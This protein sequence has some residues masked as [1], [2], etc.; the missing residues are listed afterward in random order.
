MQKPVNDSAAKN[1]FHSRNPHR[2]RYDFRQLVISCPELAEHVSVN[3]YGNESI[4][5]A[6]PAAVKMLNRALLKH[7]YGISYWDIPENYLCP[8]IPG[9]AD[10]IHYIAD[11][12]A[13]CNSGVIPRG[14]AVSVLDTGAGANCV[15]PLIGSHEYGWHF[16]GSDID[17]VSVDSAR[18]I[19]NSNIRLPELIDLRL[20]KSPA[21]IFHGI[22]KPDD[23][24]DVTICNPPFHASAEMAESGNIR[25]ISN[26]NSKKEAQTALNFG[27]QNR[28]LWTPGGE[29][30]FVRKMIDES[31]DFA[32]KCLWFTTLISKKTTLPEV[33]KALKRIK[34]AE[35]QT[36]SMAQGQKISRI[37]AW[38]FFDKIRQARWSRERWK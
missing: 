35:V 31:S 12:L 36:I 30:F 19:V 11:L 20:Q 13:S 29:E 2:F 32:G 33:Y 9:R 38:S 10:Y 14:N 3:Q 16:T 7:F 18:K 25:K 23:I 4:N 17:P 5:F 37:V 22:I 34:A 15:Y 28:E 1:G 24:F 6:D 26:L 8:P 21:N 27:G